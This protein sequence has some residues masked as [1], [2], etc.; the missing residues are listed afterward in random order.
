MSRHRMQQSSHRIA[1]AHGYLDVQAKDLDD[2]LARIEQAFA[3]EKKA[4]SVGLLGNAAEILPELVG[5]AC[6]GWSPTRPPRTIR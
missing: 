2:A 5:A 4:I 1:S 6:A 3:K